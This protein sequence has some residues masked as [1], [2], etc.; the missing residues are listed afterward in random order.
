[1][2][3]YIVLAAIPVLFVGLLAVNFVSAHGWF[4]TSPEDTAERQS[5][6]FEQKAELLGVSVEDVKNAWAEGKNFQELAEE[7]GITKE[8]LKDRMKEKMEARMKEHLQDL[9]DEGV[10]TQ[11]QA[12]KRAEI[13][14]NGRGFKKG[15]RHGFGHRF[16]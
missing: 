11:E 15:F 16:K 2:K 1:M 6:M 9:V 13:T 14:K 5:V 12:D 10:I 8:E 4:R 7:S 3:T